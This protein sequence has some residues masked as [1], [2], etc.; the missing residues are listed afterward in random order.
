M[1][2]KFANVRGMKSKAPKKE[3]KSDLFKSDY[4]RTFFSIFW[5]LAVMMNTF[6]QGAH[7]DVG[8]AGIISIFQYASAA[9][10]LMKPSSTFRLFCVAVLGVLDFYFR[11]PKM[12][13]HFFIIGVISL[14]LSLT[15][16]IKKL[17][18]GINLQWFS[19]VAPN[20]RLVFIFIYGSAAIA[21]LNSGF[22]TLQSSC[23]YVLSNREF[24]W[25]GINIDFNNYPF[26]PILISLT[27]LAVFTG[28]LNR[29]TRPYA[30][31][32]ACVF[33]TSLSLTPVSQGLGFT[34]A[35]LG[36]INLYLPLEARVFAIDKARTWQIKIDKKIPMDIFKMFYA[37]LAIVISLAFLVTSIN[38]FL[39]LAIRWF[40]T[41]LILCILSGGMIYLALKFRKTP[42]EKP[43][44][45]VSGTT[46]IVVLIL[47]ILTAISP[48]LGIKTQPTFTMYSNLSVEGNR[49]NHLFIP[50]I[51]HNSLADD[52]VTIVSSSDQNLQNDANNGVKWIYLELQR[53][54][55]KSPDTAITYIRDGK[56]FTLVKASDD[57]DL[58][59]PNPF[60]TKFL[61]FRKVFPGNICS[62]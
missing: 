14:L 41:L 17:R 57:A 50:R 44:F 31:I 54:L 29:W 48:Y 49:T 53:E 13:N 24:A 62:W 5:A 28:L 51:L 59:N 56:T 4:Q 12:P 25:L 23:A 3:I 34:F 20:L 58:I 7:L 21:K 16:I 30:I 55:K 15:L 2:A 18:G 61:S 52:I 46:Q 1:D 27:E 37:I 8:I 42:L 26:F 6:R 10:L 32:L 19:K 22:F 36:F 9:I 35:L 39:L 33:H 40:F 45:G 43:V 11:L 38:E 47:V 60:L